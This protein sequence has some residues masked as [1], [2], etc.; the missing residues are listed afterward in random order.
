MY[1]VTLNSWSM[2]SNSVA[3]WPSRTQA[4]LSMFR[5]LPRQ[6]G[7]GLRQIQAM[8]LVQDGVVRRMGLSI[9]M[10]VSPLAKGAQPSCCGDEL[11]VSTL[12][13]PSL[14]LGNGWDFEEAPLSHP[15]YV[16]N[17]PGGCTFCLMG[18]VQYAD[19]LA[20]AE[21][22]RLSDFQLS[23]A[24]RWSSCLTLEELDPA[25]RDWHLYEPPW[26]EA[27]T[28]MEP[29][30]DP[31]AYCKV[32]AYVRGRDAGSV[33]LVEALGDSRVKGL[34]PD[35][36]FFAAE[37]PIRFLSVLKG[38]ALS[39][40]PETIV[41]R[42]R[43]TTPAGPGLAPLMRKGETYAV[44]MEWDG[45]SDRPL[46]FGPCEAMT[47]SAANADEVRRGMGL[48]DPIRGYE[49]NVSLNGFSRDSA[50]PGWF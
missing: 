10:T 30:L 27:P 33:W 38:A 1:V 23:C 45:A 39:S 8:F 43:E 14:R 44:L 49:P 6:W 4:I 42:G 34:S 3:Q 15:D 24:T 2:G 5:L 25:A 11:I 13:L 35:A 40:V 7:G 19:S 12:S 46:S 28:Q 47:W 26:G 29:N 16:A 36:D 31:T 41:T 22:A 48:V 37:T 21:A 9:D 17:R 32:P 20:P 50:N 18:R